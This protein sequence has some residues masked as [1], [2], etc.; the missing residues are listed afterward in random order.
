HGSEHVPPEQRV[1][2]AHE[3]VWQAASLQMPAVVHTEPVGQLCSTQRGT[4]WPRSQTWSVGQRLLPLSTT[5]SQSLSRPSHVS[6]LGGVVSTHVSE[7]VFVHCSSP[8]AQTPW[9]P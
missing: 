5:P 3:T 9:R 7:P 2:E 6:A 4:Q 8:A 1:P